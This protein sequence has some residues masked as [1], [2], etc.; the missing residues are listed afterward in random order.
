MSAILDGYNVLVYNFIREGNALTPNDTI[1][2]KG[3]DLDKLWS[4]SEDQRRM[5]KKVASKPDFSKIK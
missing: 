2:F 4:D 3:F 1:E 5:S